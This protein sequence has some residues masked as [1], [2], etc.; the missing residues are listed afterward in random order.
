MRTGG[1]RQSASQEA[2]QATLLVG[3][4]D[5]A[6]P[7]PPLTVDATHPTSRHCSDDGSAKTRVELK[8]APLD[9]CFARDFHLAVWGS[10]SLTGPD[11]LPK[12]MHSPPNSECSTPPPELTVR[13]G[14][15]KPLRE[16]LPRPPRAYFSQRTRAEAVSRFRFRY[17]LQARVRSVKPTDPPTA[18]VC[19]H[20]SSPLTLGWPPKKLPFRTQG[21]I[22]CKQLSARP[23]SS[24]LRESGSTDS[25]ST[26]TEL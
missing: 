1:P 8:Q 23:G 21:R 17:C 10:S 11:T 22:H 26:R 7:S 2:S 6:I 20:V 15:K 3:L 24:T 13:S 5:P 9:F 25:I 14:Y 4:T 16:T 12:G 19:R 18:I